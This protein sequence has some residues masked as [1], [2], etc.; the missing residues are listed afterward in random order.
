MPERNNSI[1]LMSEDAQEVMSKIPPK[2]LRWG[3]TVLGVIIASVVIFA[4]NIKIPLTETCDFILEW[5]SE[6]EPNIVV[7]V[8]TSAIQSIIN[9]QNEVVLCSDAFPQ[10]YDSKVSAKITS[11]NKRPIIKNNEPYYIAYVQLTSIDIKNLSKY[12]IELF[13]SAIITTGYVTIIDN[14]FRIFRQ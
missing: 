7:Y 4:Y 1:E 14:I 6:V 13:G 12:K 8:P 10:E 2:I 9:G 11:V 3:I 5:N